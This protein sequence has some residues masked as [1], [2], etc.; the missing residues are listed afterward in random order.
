MS[1][2]F[3]RQLTSPSN[4]RRAASRSQSLAGPGIF[5]LGIIG[6]S[7]AIAAHFPER[8]SQSLSLPPSFM[9]APSQGPSSPIPES[10]RQAINKAMSAAEL[11]QSATYREEWATVAKLWQE[12]IYLLKTIPETSSQH[13]V[14]QQKIGEYERNLQYAKTNV[15]TRPAKLAD[16]TIP[17]WTVGSTRELLVAVQGTP[18]RIIRADSR[19]EEVVY[20]GNSQVE[21]K[22]GMVVHYDDLD[23]NLKVSVDAAA[24]PIQSTNAWTLGSSKEEVFRVQGTPSRVRTFN[25]LNTEVLYYGDSLIELKNDVVTAYSDF[26]GRLKVTMA[27]ILAGFPADASPQF[28]QLGSQRA[29]VFRIQDTPTQVQRDDSFCREVLHYGDSTIDLQ[30]GIVVGYNNFDNNLKVK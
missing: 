12:A 28:W 1:D 18:T 21:L 15:T 2:D 16:G 20:Y 29:E 6:L 26:D 9:A 22:Y 19:C 14:A 23:N 30:N 10:F 3:S 24:S 11:T 5:M 8:F 13:S 4:R 27:P 17:F 7:A 25:S